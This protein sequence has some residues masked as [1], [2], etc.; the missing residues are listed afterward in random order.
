MSEIRD[1]KQKLMILQKQYD[2]RPAP[3]LLEQIIKLRE[4][5]KA[6]RGSRERRFGV[7]VTLDEA[8]VWY[9]HASGDLREMLRVILETEGN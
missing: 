8:R 3:A 1:I 6:L 7:S 4:Q 9:P 2:R 5:R